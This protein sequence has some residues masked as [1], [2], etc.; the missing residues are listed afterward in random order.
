LFGAVV[1][2]THISSVTLTETNNKVRVLA[3]V[4]SD[5][6]VASDQL[7]STSAT[8]D[9]VETVSFSYGRISITNYGS[10][11]GTFCWDTATGRPCSSGN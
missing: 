10:G 11:G 2:G 1:V 8:G 4:L 3:I 7:G 9:P 6:I 5:V